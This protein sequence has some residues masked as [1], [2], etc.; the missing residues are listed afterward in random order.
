MSVWLL[1]SRQC[2]KS[3]KV[4]SSGDLSDLV[5][6][7]VCGIFYESVWRLVLRLTHLGHRYKRRQRSIYS[8]NSGGRKHMLCC[9]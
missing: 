3:E 5:A 1:T 8:L 7:F 2:R 9:T 4:R 6:R